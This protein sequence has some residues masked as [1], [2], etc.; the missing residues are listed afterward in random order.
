MQMHIKLAGAVLMQLLCTSTLISAVYSD[1]WGVNGELWEPGAPLNDFSHVGY[2]G[3]DVSFPERPIGVNIKDFGAKGDGNADDTQALRDAINACPAQKAVF[4]PV[5][6]YIIT[7]WIKISNL[8]NITIRGEDMY[9]TQLI[10]PYSLSDLHPSPTY[11]TG[12]IP[13]HSYSWEGGFF[14]FENAEEL[15]I[16]NLNFIFPDIPWVEHF[17]L[18]GYNMIHISGSNNWIKNVR[19]YNADCGIFVR[20]SYMTLTNILL[21]AFPGRPWDRSSV[22]FGGRAGHHAIDM[23]GGDYNLVEN[24]TETIKYIH[25]LG[26]EGSATWNVW[27]RCKGPDIE[28]DHHSSGIGHNLFTDIDMGK[29]WGAEGQRSINSNGNMETYWNLRSDTL[30]PFDSSGAGIKIGMPVLEDWQKTIVVGWW[31]PWP[32]SEKQ[33]RS[34]SLPWYE[35]IGNYDDIHPRNLYIAQLKKRLNKDN[36]AP[37]VEI[38]RPIDGVTYSGVATVTA[39][40]DDR[41]GS[42]QNVQL[43]VDGEPIGTKASGTYEWELMA[44]TDGGHIIE[45][46]A[47]DNQNATATDMVTIMITDGVPSAGV[48]NPGFEYGM[49]YWQTLGDT[50]ADYVQ[51]TNP[52]TGTSNLAHWSSDAY[53]VYTYQTIVGLEE[54]LYTLV[55]WVKSTGGQNACYISA[56]DFGG[57]ELKQNVPA[58]ETYV[59]IE[60]PNIIVTGGQCRIGLWSDSPGGKWVAMD[61]VEFS[62]V[63][64]CGFDLPDVLDLSSDWLRGIEA[65]DSE[66]LHRYNFDLDTLDAVGPNGVDLVVAGAASV[67]GTL[68]TYDEVSGDGP[69]AYAVNNPLPISDFTGADG[70]FTFEAF[71]RPETEY[72]EQSNTMQI[73]SMD[74]NGIDSVRGWHLGIS[75]D[76]KLQFLKITG[77]FQKFAAAI[78]TTGEHAYAAD[79]W[80]HVAVTYNGLEGTADNLKLYWTK[81]DSEIEQ[82]SLLG[83]FSLNEDLDST[84]MSNFAVGNELRTFGGYSENF[85]GLID[86]VR[87]SSVAREPSDM[88]RSPSFE[89]V[90]MD[91]SD[92][93]LVDLFDFAI[94][95]SEWMKCGV[96]ENIGVSV[97]GP[98]TG[99][100]ATVD[101]GT[102]FLDWNANPEV[103]L[104]GYNVYRSVT[105]GSGYTKLN[106]DVITD[107]IYSDSTSG[108]G[109]IYYYVIT[110]V[111]MSPEESIYSDEVSASPEAAEAIVSLEAENGYVGSHWIIGT[112]IDASGGSYIEVDPAYSNWDTTPGCTTAD[113]L[114]TY[115]FDITTS[116]DYRFWFRMFADTASNDSF[117]WRI[118]N[119]S[120]I[121]ENNRYGDGLWFSSDAAQVDDLSIGHHVLQIANREAGAGLDKFVIQLDSLTEPSGNGPA[122]NN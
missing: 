118:D 121:L 43:R 52:H 53:Q 100:T 15:G 9:E 6:N 40:V 86:E 51:T 30:I 111:D 16:E 105:S 67:D 12:N 24:Y 101:G 95:C 35:H 64:D 10:F 107:L 106:G 110:A 57:V 108:I 119:E 26:C 84:V 5:G 120:W 71:I 54:G 73:M 48:V 37:V 78:P 47:T 32:E 87:I 72:D 92:D 117:F 98:P 69:V 83:S 97:P 4:I 7:D 68:N 81:V 46:T 27:C 21:D 2:R 76:N 36:L 115:N 75:L 25:S 33:K 59:Q 104:F 56:K 66:T 23:Q 39:M 8:K 3:G 80:Y 58:T 62:M 14:W 11:T 94:L 1:L 102:V 74:N 113:C 96:L 109:Q 79:S 114:V 90:L 91:L 20:G 88:L 50:A 85:E 63:D 93:G 99:L 41:D 38:T 55:A 19:G 42:I 77:S 89:P 28:I 49:P 17:E 29:G 70:V 61:D 116:G 60:I 13:T 65:E 45:V 122:E 31:L 34:L 22:V 44:L 18:T 82:A 103:D 112:N